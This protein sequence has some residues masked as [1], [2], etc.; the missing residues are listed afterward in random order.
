MIRDLQWIHLTLSNEAALTGISP[1]AWTE[2]VAGCQTMPS[3]HPSLRKRVDEAADELIAV[4]E[5]IRKHH[6]ELASAYRAFG[7][8]LRGSHNLTAGMHYVAFHLPKDCFIGLEG[9]SIQRTQGPV[10]VHIMMPGC[11]F[12]RFGKF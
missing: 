12:M 4:A 7:Q 1:C 6:P 2:N 8:G 9:A 10:D 5:K 3:I 11:D